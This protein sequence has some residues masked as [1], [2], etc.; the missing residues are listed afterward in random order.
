VTRH[1]IV[2]AVSRLTPEGDRIWLDAILQHVEREAKRARQANLNGI[3]LHHGRAADGDK[4]SNDGELV[5]ALLRLVEL[6]DD[7]DEFLAAVVEDR[8]VK[9]KISGT[10]I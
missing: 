4:T 10:S 9:K 6:R 7:M 1:Q 3:K 5:V 8:R 2:K